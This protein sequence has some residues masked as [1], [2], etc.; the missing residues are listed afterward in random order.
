M[1]WCETADAAPRRYHAA[2]IDK[3]NSD[4]EELINDKEVTCTQPQ[5]KIVFS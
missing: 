5:E 3:E 4:E 1:L 2:S